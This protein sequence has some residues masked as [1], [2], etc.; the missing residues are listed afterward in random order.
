MRKDQIFVLLLVILLPMSGCFDGA[1]GDAEGADDTSDDQAVN[2]NI[3]INP[4]VMTVHIPEGQTHSVTLN[5]STLQVLD[6]WYVNSDDYWIGG[7]TIPFLMNCSNGFTMSSFASANYDY[8]N[9]YL[10]ILP[11]IE[12]TV[13]LN[14]QSSN[15]NG[16]PSEKI[17]ILTEANLKSLN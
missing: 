6:I 2:G 10:P 14:W 11:D 1:V 16:G 3:S 9:M 8:D 12:C 15:E 4:T 17:V 7:G 13:E 5:G